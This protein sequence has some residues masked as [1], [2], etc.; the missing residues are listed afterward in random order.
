V[1]HGAEHLPAI[2]DL[3]Y[4]AINFAIFAWVLVRALSGPIREYFRERAERLR[5]EL[6]AGERARREAEA[7][8]A[9]LA[10]ELAD[11][12]ATRD[13]LKADLLATAERERDQLLAM[14]K[15]NAERIRNDARL[16]ADQEVAAARR[17]LRDEVVEH[18]V[19]KAS[20][21]V[22]GSTQADDEKRY[23]DEFI[24]GAGALA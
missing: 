6:A 21:L 2:G 20:D 9:Q 12:P 23:V 17:M 22:R 8:R 19:A 15:Q 24:R 5:E 18:A 4:P 1:E 14:A 13:R 7:L 11:L 16:L 10:R 3:F